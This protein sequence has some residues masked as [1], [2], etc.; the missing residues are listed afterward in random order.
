M[1]DNATVQYPP[2]EAVAGSAAHDPAEQL[3]ILILNT[4]LPIFPGGGGVEYLTTKQMAGLAD[5]VGLVSMAHTRDA[6][7]K[8][9]GLA[10]AGVDLYLWHSPYLDQVPVRGSYSAI[11][12]QLHHWLGTLVGWYQAWPGRP[13]DT[14]II[15]GCFRNMSAPLSAALAER[16]W[17]VLS[18]IESSAARMIDYL[19]RQRVSILVMHDIRALLYERQAQAST[20]RWER[21]R[22]LRQA[23]RYFAFEQFYS[24]RYDL[25]AT[26][27]DHDAAWVREHYQP[28]RV[29]TVPLPVDTQYFR[30]APAESEQPDRIVFTGLMNHPPNAD[31]AVYFAREILPKIRQVRPQAEFYIVGRHPTIAVQ[32]LSQLPGVHVTGS[33]PDI[34]P[35]IAS[36]TVVVVPLRYGSGAR[37]KILEA[38]GMEKCVVSTTL[39]AEGLAYRDNVNLAIADDA[40]QM[41][42][43]V[44]EALST[45]AFRDRLRHAGRAVAVQN[46]HPVQIARDYHH[47]IQQVVAEKSQRDEPMRVAID[48][49]WMIPGMAGGLENLARSFMHRLLALDRYNQYTA[50]LPVRSRYDFD[51]RGHANVRVVSRDSLGEYWDRIRRAATR[52]VFAK[53]R[54]DHWESPEV[55]NLRFARSLD[56]EIAYSFP[57]YVHPDVYP[58]RQVLMVPDIQHEYF[59]EFFPPSA[60]E[61]RRRLYGDSIRRAD[62]ICAISEFTRQTLI[63][64]LGVAPEKITTIHLAADPAFTLTADPQA[65][66]ER[67]RK[68]RL[69]P[70]TYLYFPAHTWHHKNHRAA[71]EALRILRDK[72]GRTPSL[73]CSGGAREAQPAI[74]EQLNTYGLQNQV[75][76][77]GYCPH[78]DVP[79]LY[80]GAAC[81]LFP[82][83][84]EGFGMPVLEAMASGCP[85]VCSNTTSLP[86]IAA[87]AALL[88]DPADAEAFADALARVLGDAGLRAELCMRGLR[89]ATRF[90]WQRHTI[91]TIA[92]FYRLHRQIRGL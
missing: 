91:E 67:L 70:G 89:Q 69:E 3:N 47:A 28:R 54:L 84:F 58:L 78:D 30:P 52:R 7:N 59:P 40:D 83:L 51:L 1:F 29:I 19:P 24:R 5:H 62:Q 60:L 11:V 81:L 4:H 43:T 12:R 37:Q 39:G 38:W 77:L 25:V 41:A 76:F 17:S 57:G 85:V 88:A 75:R 22:L 49:R 14:L 36:A 82:S 42:A 13:A 44:V 34:R 21:W 87:D 46:H 6:L 20:S 61:E 64:R 8:T 50:I 32:A 15:D 66:R 80:R 45:H 73:V 48:M 33:V 86:E 72:H 79:A 56:A 16:P 2:I 92:V 90:S 18:V 35:F 9:E 10:E 55:M 71:I 23:R 65:D 31:A 27:S 26:V 63:E 53:L 74:E 68:Y